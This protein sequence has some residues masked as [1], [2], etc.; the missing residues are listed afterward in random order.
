M[1]RFTL[2]W[3]ALHFTLHILKKGNSNIKCLAY[4]SLVH[5]ILEYGVACWGIYRV[6]K[7]N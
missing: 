6:K 1:Q 3:K 7:E 5:P 4:T 2:G